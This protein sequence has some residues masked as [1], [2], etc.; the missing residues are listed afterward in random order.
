MSGL[1]LAGVGNYREIMDMDFESAVY[2]FTIHYINRINE[3]LAYE[4]MKK[5]NKHG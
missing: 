5:V 3:N 2:T 4:A 1:V